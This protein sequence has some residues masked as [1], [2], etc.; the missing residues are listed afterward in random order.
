MG[1]VEDGLGG[2]SCPCTSPPS[3]LLP[4]PIHHPPQPLPLFSAMISSPMEKMLSHISHFQCVGVADNGAKIWTIKT[5]DSFCVRPQHGG[6]V[7]EEDLSACGIW[8]RKLWSWGRGWR[9]E[10]AHPPSSFGVQCQCSPAHSPNSTLPWAISKLRSTRFWLQVGLLLC[11]G[12][13]QQLLTTVFVLELPHQPVLPR[14][15]EGAVLLQRCCSYT[16]SC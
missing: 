16:W 4:L 10:R 9:G 6:I 14:W 1:C 13:A 12:A 8:G 15:G 2:F 11:W 5:P 3:L 7:L